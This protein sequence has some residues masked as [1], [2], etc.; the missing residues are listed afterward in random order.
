MKVLLEPFVLREV[1]AIPRL[2]PGAKETY[3]KL[4]LHPKRTIAENSEVLGMH[5]E[6]LRRHVRELKAFDLAY[7][8]PDTRTGRAIVVPWMPLATEESL[9][10]QWV[11]NR[12]D[13]A[14][15]G[16]WIAGRWLELLVDELDW[17]EEA[18][19]EFLVSGFGSNRLE[20]D[21]FFR[22][23]RVAIEFQGRYHFHAGPSKEE[24]DRLRQQQ[25]RDGLKALRLSREDYMFV[26][27]TGADL[28]YETITNKLG[29]VLPLIP[30][31]KDRPLFRRL[32]TM[33]LGYANHIH[34]KS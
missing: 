24:Q 10:Q 22:R 28:H 1:M 3:V 25:T 20:I 27:L 8:Y 23:A 18:R 21:F 29:Q 11:Q 14:Y 26:E 2:Y 16:Q 4:C 7:T 34:K 33:S 19:P 9:T 13:F 15:Q 12:A 31:R 30:P 5:Y 6:T 32:T 17:V